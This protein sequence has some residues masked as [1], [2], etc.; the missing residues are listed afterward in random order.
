MTGT[1]QQ[2]GLPAG[3][4]SRRY[5][6]LA[7]ICLLSLPLS[8]AAQSGT[9]YNNGAILQINDLAVLQV[10]GDFNNQ[11]GSSYNND[12]TII[13]TGNV[14][15]NQVMTS[16][17][18]GVL[19]FN[20]TGVQTLSGTTA[21]YASDIE[22]NNASGV[23]LSD[24][25]KVAGVC[26]F[27][28][29]IVSAAATTTPL[30][31][32]STGTISST[33]AAKDISHVNGYVVKEGT[34]SFS[35]P[36]GNGIRYQR[37]DVNLTANAAGMRV[38]YDTTNAGS[39]SFSAAGTDPTPLLAYN[40]LE[41]WDMTPL[42]TATGTV[43][44]FWDNYR[45]IGITN[46]A[47][48]KVA[49]KTGGTWRNEGT[50]GTGTTGAGSV[51]SNSL[52]TWSPFTLG[53]INAGSSLPLSI[54]A[55]NG[56]T[57][58]GYNELSWETANEQ[59][60]TAFDL[61]KSLDGSRFTAIASIDAKGASGNQYQYQDAHNKAGNVF[62][63][64]RINEASM[65][66]SYSNTLKLQTSGG[67]EHGISLYPNPATGTVTL[68]IPDQQLLHSQARLTDLSG[69]TVLLISVNSMHQ[70]VD[71]SNLPAGIYLLAFDNGT[72]LRFSKND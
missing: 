34:G 69:K 41:S 8:A 67:T 48:L 24:T 55:F 27:I 11:A 57:G 33:N 56:K 54:I 44:M 4:G 62:Y 59:G 7:G 16:P 52:S 43:T 65:Q 22:V 72:T 2:P 21:I 71:L 13:V 39:A 30:W 66:Y 20:G 10:N 5:L 68:S 50:T 49:H 42:S 29:G 64:L 45:N 51:T 17:Y 46:T 36:V 15:N 9:L 32:T 31:F 58:N 40:T 37:A 6:R 26:S 14:T 19:R 47:H 38:R 1:S 53:S 18:T 60:I 25:L 63:R 61:E 28:N 70:S 23:V 35:Y 12:G 3:A